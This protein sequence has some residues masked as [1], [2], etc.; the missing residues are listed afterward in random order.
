M[1]SIELEDFMKRHGM[2]YTDVAALVGVTPQAVWQWLQDKR[3]ISLTV[4]R[5]LHLFDRHP[6]VMAGFA[7]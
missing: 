1:T 5:L 2:S 3:S 4:S 6:E 7:S